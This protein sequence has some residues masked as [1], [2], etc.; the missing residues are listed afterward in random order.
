MCQLTIITD[1]F[2]DQIKIRNAGIKMVTETQ[3][4]VSHSGKETIARQRL[5]QLKIKRA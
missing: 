4:G 2:P 3:K 5:H 1:K